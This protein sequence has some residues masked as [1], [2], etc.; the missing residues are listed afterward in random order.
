MF[1]Y[2]F[3]MTSSRQISLN[4]IFFSIGLT[5]FHIS[6]SFAFFSSVWN[7]CAFCISFVIRRMVSSISSITIF[8]SFGVILSFSYNSSSV[9]RWKSLATT[10]GY[11]LRGL[12]GNK[13]LA[14]CILL[15][16]TRL[17]GTSRF[18]IL[19][20][21]LYP[22]PHTSSSISLQSLFHFSLFEAFIALFSS[23]FILLSSSSSLWSIFL[24]LWALV[25]LLLARIASVL[26]LPICQVM[27]IRTLWNIQNWLAE[28]SF[29]PLQLMC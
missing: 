17:Y 3:P 10:I 9:K 18:I 16:S 13:C 28:S 7:S 1:S 14:T 29:I 19:T 26:N 15:T 12:S 24:L 25:V 11:S 21:N 4:D 23:F 20:T 22:L 27:L 8:N 5:F 6:V 2:S